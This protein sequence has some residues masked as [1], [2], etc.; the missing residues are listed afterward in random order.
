MELCKVYNLPIKN[1]AHCR[2]SIKCKFASNTCPNTR[3]YLGNYCKDHTCIYTDCFDRKINRFEYCVHH[4]CSVVGCTCERDNSYG[5][6][7]PGD[8]RCTNCDAFILTG[9]LCGECCCMRLDC[10]NR[11]LADRSHCEFHTCDICIRPMTYCMQHREIKI[12]DISGGLM[13]ILPKDIAGIIG[14]YVFSG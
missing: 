2:R 1:C 5:K 10:I 8:T 11:R 7:Y 13:R 4:K 6:D 3:L 12:R 9:K 14:Y